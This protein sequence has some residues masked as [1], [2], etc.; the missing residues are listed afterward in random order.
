ME[1]KEGESFDQE[2][3]G[4]LIDVDDQHLYALGKLHKKTLQPKKKWIGM[5]DAETFIN[6]WRN[7]CIT[8]RSLQ[9]RDKRFFHDP[10]MCR[11]DF[12]PGEGMVNV[13]EVSSNIRHGHYLFSSK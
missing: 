12:Q 13:D 6:D 7:N 1:P 3:V 10:L 4:S 2:Y 11:G 5:F 9:I 8:E